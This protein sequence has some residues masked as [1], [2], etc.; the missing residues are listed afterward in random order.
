VIT[1]DYRGVLLNG[2]YMLASD[3]QARNGI[4]H[5]VDSLILPAKQQSSE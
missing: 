2:A 4:V 5:V 1:K 3:I